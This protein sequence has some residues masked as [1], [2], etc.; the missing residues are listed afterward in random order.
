M[1]TTLKTSFFNNN[2]NTTTIPARLDVIGFDAEILLQ[3]NLTMDA[4]LVPPRAV[5]NLNTGGV[6]RV[7][8]GS[9]DLFG[10]AQLDVFAELVV[11][12]G[13]LQVF[14]SMEIDGSSDLT[15]NGGFAAIDEGFDVGLDHPAEVVVS[16]AAALFTVGPT[17]LG[18][19]LT[20]TGRVT[21]QDVGSRWEIRDTVTIGDAGVGNAS[22]NNGGQLLV[23]D[24]AAHVMLG[25]ST[26]GSGQITVDSGLAGGSTF[27][28]QASVFLGGND[29]AAGGS[30]HLLVNQGSSANI[31]G[32]IN[33]WGQGR[34]EA[35]GGSIASSQLTVTTG[36]RLIID[37]GG[38]IEANIVDL[39]TG[40]NLSGF[41]DG[42]L[43]VRGAPGLT[44]SLLIGST[45][46]GF[47]SDSG[48]PTIHL[49][50]ATSFVT[51][52][53]IANFPGAS[54]K[55]VV[56]GPLSRLQASNDLR[57]TGNNT[58]TNGE[59]LIQNGGLAEAGDDITMAFTST[60]TA[61]VIVDGIASNG[62]RSTL[63]NNAQG[64]DEEIEIGRG[65]QATLT[66]TSGG[67]VQSLNNV[68]LASFPMAAGR[69]NGRRPTGDH[70]RE[71]R[72]GRG[73]LRHDRH[74]WRN[75]F[76]DR[77]QPRSCACRQSVESVLPGY[78]R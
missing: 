56:E 68:S 77:Q 74:R 64:Q 19:N 57:V 52:W 66:V 44:G 46:F 45:S 7:D 40:A 22:V 53:T 14:G 27:Q 32:L 9:L 58:Q 11:D 18:T 61:T 37:Q 72:Y 36:G 20:G 3:G 13:S 71:Q 1:N 39:Q 48:L 15:V 73:R 76:L 69:R 35:N 6:L 51:D 16:N 62:R 50:D 33:V 4:G 42:T 75:R 23:L 30:G 34:V 70:Q 63:R 10:H 31:D 28:S 49:D 59:M 21:I 67:L 24:P 65:G 60:S 8:G 29:S 5:V 25:T 38:S 78:R 26:S 54:A 55:T 2:G 17:V 12:A 43:I 47:G 41:D